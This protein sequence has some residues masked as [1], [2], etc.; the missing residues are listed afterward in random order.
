MRLH[1]HV[2][3]T[4]ALAAGFSCS[5]LSATAG[6]SPPPGTI[7]P[8]P[9]QD[10]Q[11]LRAL[12]WQPEEQIDLAKAK[13]AIDHLTDPSI[14]EA[15]TLKEV[16]AWVAKVQTRIPAGANTWAKVMAIY[17]TIYVPGP[18]NNNHK[19]DYNFDDP[20]GKDVHTT[21]LS[22][23][24]ATKRGNCV[25]MPIF[26]A[27]LA[28]RIGLHVA[29]AAAP[30]HLLVKIKL[31]NGQWKNIEATSGST[32]TD[33]EYMQRFQIT[34]QAV[35]SGLYLRA[36]TMREAVVEMA[37]PFI[38]DYAK[39]HSPSQIMAMA[40]L[41]LGYDPK[42]V[43][44]IMFKALAYDKQVTLLYRSKYPDPRML[45][46]AQQ[47]DY[48]ALMDGYFAESDQLQALGWHR[49]SAE[50]DTEYMQSIQQAK[51]NEKGG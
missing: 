1:L 47:A 11:H 26:F 30:N 8:V 3:V 40:D 22:T 24:L 25:S 46:P 10:A 13:V 4:F 37:T 41:A 36:L 27:I 29:L 45:T 12:L 15:A 51:A 43:A 7:I 32:L 39:S 14:D 17:S 50:Q 6:T 44:G 48:K 38:Q 31:D 19:F 33:Q 28:Q 18:W 34:P 23:Y 16:V 42:D 9:D 35:S 20:F 21:M 5:C 49:R 2:I